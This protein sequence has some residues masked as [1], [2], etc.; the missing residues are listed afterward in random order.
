[1]SS[2]ISS[3]AREISS[4]DRFS[5]GDNWARFLSVLD[6]E[7]ISLAEKSLKEFLETDSLAGKSFLDIGSGSG[8]MSLVARRMGANVHSFDYD[9]KSVACTQELRRRYFADDPHWSIEEGSVLDQAFLD[10]LGQFDVVYAWGVLHHT[11]DQWKALAS[12]DGLVSPGGKLFIA[13][14]N[15]QGP[16][17]RLWR[18]AKK[19]YVSLPSA[20]RF[21]VLVPCF[22]VMFGPTIIWDTLH[23]RPFHAFQ[24][25][26]KRFRGMSVVRD[27][28]DW[29]GGY[30][31]ETSTPEQ[32]FRFFKGRGYSLEKLTT[33]AGDYG[34]N[35]FV[36]QKKNIV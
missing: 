6:E 34:C 31:F 19:A 33:N 32:V 22:L 20:L 5:F 7:R 35:Q 14:Y 3:H 29:V 21:L 18:W 17:S 26:S 4:G 28:V 30:P 23:G 12:S 25:Y 1:M 9:P 15:H 11:G 36:F 13:L 10:K 24:T 2:S 16:K 8:L 27:I